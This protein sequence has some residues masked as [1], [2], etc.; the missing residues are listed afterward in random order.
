RPP[1]QHREQATSLQGRLARDR[2]AD[3]TR[4]TDS[5]ERGTIM[6]SLRIIGLA[7]AAAAAAIVVFA[8]PAGATYPG[9]NGRLAFGMTARARGRAAGRLFGASGGAGDSP[10]HRRSRLRRLRGLFGRWRADRVLQ[11][12][13]RPAWAVRH[14]DDEAERQ[15]QAAPDATRRERDLPRLL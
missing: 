15:R 5:I 7:C 10:D 12:P 2:A 9:A 13:G 4:R 8:T 1:P 3:S 14:L 6:R 11:W